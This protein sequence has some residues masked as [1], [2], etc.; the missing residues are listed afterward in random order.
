MTPIQ[1]DVEETNEIGEYSSS[2]RS[3]LSKIYLF[4]ILLLNILNVR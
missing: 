2:A 4:S 1:I 3:H